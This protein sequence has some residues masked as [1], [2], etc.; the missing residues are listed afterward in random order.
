[1]VAASDY[2]FRCL[3]RQYY[4]SEQHHEDE[5]K[6]KYETPYQL[7]TFTQMLHSKH[8]VQKETFRRD[9]LDLY[10]CLPIDKPNDYLD[11]D[12]W[13][14][15]QQNMMRGFTADST[16][17]SLL[18]S[19]TKALQAQLQSQHQQDDVSV[20]C[21]MPTRGPL[22]VQLAGHDVSQVVDAAQVVY[23]NTQGRVHGVDLNLGRV[24]L[25]VCGWKRV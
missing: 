21:S 9:H 4:G 24:L 17:A 2:A 16:A 19:K 14:S 25:V 5:T 20:G 6:T 23:Q 12:T 18:H 3:C 1:M 11:P 10:E 13:S 8:L 7:L 22:I 15:A